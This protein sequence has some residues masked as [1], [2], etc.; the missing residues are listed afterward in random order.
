MRG[1]EAL[2]IGEAAAGKMRPLDAG[3]IE[4]LG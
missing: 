1:Y 3:M 2:Q 4:K